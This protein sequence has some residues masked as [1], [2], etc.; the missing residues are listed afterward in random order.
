[1][2][3]SNLNVTTNIPSLVRTHLHLYTITYPVHKYMY[4]HICTRTHN[5]YIH[6]SRDQ[7]WD[8]ALVHYYMRGW[9][10]TRQVGRSLYKHYRTYSLRYRKLWPH[11][12]YHSQGVGRAS[13]DIHYYNGLLDI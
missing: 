10:T 5:Y 2:Y 7:D 12:L 8:C 1:M 13:I 9:S 11:A 6:I 4:P 3:A